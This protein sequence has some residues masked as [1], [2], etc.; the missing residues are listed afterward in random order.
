M[1]D[2]PFSHLYFYQSLNRLQRGLSAIAELLVIDIPRQKVYWSQA[3]QRETF[4]EA[5]NALKSPGEA[6]TLPT[7][8]SQMGVDT[9]PI[10]HPLDAFGVSV[11]ASPAPWL[12]LFPWILWCWL[13][14]RLWYPIETHG[15]PVGTP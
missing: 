9:L 12:I 1:L 15:Y 6:M 11:W 10:P 3:V 13:K 2:A 5:L 8:S 14:H 7:P 4:C